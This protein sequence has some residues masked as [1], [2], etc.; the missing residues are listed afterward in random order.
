[1]ISPLRQRFAPLPATPG[2][3]L[4]Q[5]PRAVGMMQLVGFSRPCSRR[6]LASICRWAG[7][8]ENG[9]SKNGLSD[10][11]VSRLVTL[12]ARQGPGNRYHHSGH[13]AHVVMAAAILAGS[14]GLRAHD[15]DLLVV[16][17][18]IHDLNH[19]GKRSSKRL[20]H[21][22]RQSATAARRI[23][24]GAGADA[25]LAAR[26]EKLL[27][28]TALTDDALRMTIL[29]SDPL[30]RLLADADI[31][32][33]VSY[34]RDIALGLTRNLKLEQRIPGKADDLLRHFAG[35]IGK[36]G[37]HSGA[38]RRLLAS[39]VASRQAGLNTVAV[40]DVGDVVA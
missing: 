9:Q 35:R 38:G 27:I 34:R 13:F 24:I 30:A 17:A 28:A 39:T 19:L 31:F 7:L 10:R 37:L 25:R 2:Y 18:L 11:A 23:I 29:A 6:D 36:V 4:R 12:A 15:R 32:A 33:S 40:D 5:W 26:L 8:S 3:V 20:F 16:A 21:Q 14:D 1:M 22:E